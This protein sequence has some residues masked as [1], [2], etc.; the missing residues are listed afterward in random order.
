MRKTSL[1]LPVN[2]SEAGAWL[3]KWIEARYGGRPLQYAVAAD[4]HGVTVK[5]VLFQ[6]RA[7]E[8]RLLEYDGLTHCE[9]ICEANEYM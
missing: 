6:Q 1:Q 5:D 3:G 9:I 7:I 4:R 8:V 2:E